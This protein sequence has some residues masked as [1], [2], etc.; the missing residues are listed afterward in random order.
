M[1]DLYKL[2]AAGYLASL[3]LL[4]VLAGA[5]CVSDWVQNQLWF[6]IPEVGVRKWTE[7]SLGAA[8][9]IAR[10]IVHQNANFYLHRMLCK[11]W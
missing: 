10:H 11:N 7:G 4:Q 6:E 8:H 9:R 2:Q 5:T 3:L 1:D